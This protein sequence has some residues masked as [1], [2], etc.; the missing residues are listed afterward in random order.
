M[1]LILL[2]CLVE[3]VKYSDRACCEIGGNTPSE[4]CSIPDEMMDTNTM[5]MGTGGIV[6]VI[7][8]SLFITCCCGWVSY[9]KCCKPRTNTTKTIVPPVPVPAPSAPAAAIPTTNAL[10]VASA[11][12]VQISF[13]HESSLQSS[14]S[15]SRGSFNLDATNVNAEMSHSASAPPMNPFY[16]GNQGT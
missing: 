2:I 10:P 12:P 11:V 6:G 9:K 14:K 7:I 1:I 4:M 5:A 8:A 13:G 16:D 15:I 3:G